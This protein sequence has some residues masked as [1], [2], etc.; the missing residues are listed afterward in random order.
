MDVT[1]SPSHQESEP[2]QRYMTHTNQ[3]TQRMHSNCGL[4][5]TLVLLITII[6]ALLSGA[7]DVF[8]FFS[9]LDL[10]ATKWPYS[11]LDGD[12]N[13]NVTYMY[14]TLDVNLLNLHSIPMK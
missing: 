13:N 4:I 1:H 2:T 3:T 6:L 9:H 5:S 12:I 14:Q 8:F 11:H 10:I 7:M